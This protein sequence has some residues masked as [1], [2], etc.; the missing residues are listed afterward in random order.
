[1]TL[2]LD[3][4]S[5]HTPE[6]VAAR[7][8]LKSHSV[9]QAVRDGADATRLER[10]RMMFTVE[11]ALAVRALL[12]GQGVVPP[13]VPA[14]AVVPCDGDAADTGGSS[15]AAIRASTAQGGPVNSR[16]GLAHA[17]AARRAAAG[18]KVVAE[19]SSTAC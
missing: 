15:A 11:Q 18:G 10:G 19:L 2:P 17:H 7:F 9:R 5:L 12:I 6:A 13:A 14:G 3:P 8:G 16:D 4:W 1:M